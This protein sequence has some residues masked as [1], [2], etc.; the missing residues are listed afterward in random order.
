MSFIT[1]VTQSNVDVATSANN[2]IGGRNRNTSDIS[3]D[4]GEYNVVGINV[5][6]IED[7]KAAVNEYIS[8]VDNL[9]YDFATSNDST[10]AF[11]G[12]G[13]QE[14]ITNYLEKVKG[15]VSAVTHTLEAFNTKL[16]DVKA[17]Y[18]SNISNMS[19]EINQSANSINY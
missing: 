19:S 16:D 13:M 1:A 14:A 6:K 11:R 7:M 3:A 12:E 10:T 4:Y 5:N 9:L 2:L 15:Y 8:H 17:A 18:E